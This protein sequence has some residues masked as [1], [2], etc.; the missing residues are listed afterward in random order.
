MALERAQK[1]NA[2]LSESLADEQADRI[3]YLLKSQV[4]LSDLLEQFV[5]EQHTFNCLHAS[6]VHLQSP[7]TGHCCLC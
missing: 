5:Y 4:I 7:D 1:T 6:V 3:L 2:E